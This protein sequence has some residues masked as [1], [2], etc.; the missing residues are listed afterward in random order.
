MISYSETKALNLTDKVK[1]IYIYSPRTVSIKGIKLR[2]SL[3][4]DFM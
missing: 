3:S 1:N 2:V 4:V